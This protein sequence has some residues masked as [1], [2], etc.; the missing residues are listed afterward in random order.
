MA[1]FR[2]KFPTTNKVWIL[3]F[4]LGSTQYIIL[5]SAT[6]IWLTREVK[7]VITLS[8]NQNVNKIIEFIYENLLIYTTAGSTLLNRD[9]PSITDD[10]KWEFRCGFLRTNIKASNRCFKNHIEFKCRM[11]QMTVQ[12]NTTTNY[13]SPLL[14]F[15]ILITI[16]K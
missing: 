2:K 6:K 10:F 16:N 15:L 8:P 13:S 12:Q 11:A 14:Q 7:A 9:L 1:E 5:F 4:P 3:S